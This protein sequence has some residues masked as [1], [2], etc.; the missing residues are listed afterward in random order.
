[1]SAYSLARTRLIAGVNAHA[2]LSTKAPVQKPLEKLDRLVDAEHVEA[3]AVA[4]DAV[5][6]SR[7]CL[8]QVRVKHDKRDG[9]PQTHASLDIF[10][11]V[12]VLPHSRHRHVESAQKRRHES[13]CAC[14]R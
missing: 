11:P 8:A 2:P 3:L 6:H 4:P 1:M 9:C 12:V 14:E 13:R 7:V 10:E 5:L